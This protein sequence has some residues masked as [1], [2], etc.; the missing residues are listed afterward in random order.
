VKALAI[1][2]D[3]R[4]E[5]VATC[6]VGAAAAIYALVALYLTR[7][8]VPTYDSMTWLVDAAG[9]QSPGEIL[10][11]HN[12]HL[13]AVTRAFYA[14]SLRIFGTDPVAFEAFQITAVIATAVLLF[15][16]L[17]QRIDSLVAASAAVLVL[18]LGSPVILEPTVAVFAQSAA[19]G[20]GALLALGRGD[21]VGDALG[22]LLLLAGVAAFS[23]GLAFVA[24]AAA[25][26]AARRRWRDAWIVLVP[27]AAYVAWYAWASPSEAAGS[28]EVSAANVLLIPS[29]AADSLAAGLAVLAGLGVDLNEATPGLVS[30]G[31]GRIMA[32]AFVLLLVYVYLIRRRPLSAWV[33]ALLVIALAYWSMQAIVSQEF[34]GPL[35]DRYVFLSAVLCVLLLVELARGVPTARLVVIAAALLAFALPPSLAQMRT[36]GNDMRARSELAKAD[37]GAVELARDDLD[38]SMRVSSGLLQPVAA[39][40]YLEMADSYGALGLSPEEIEAAPPAIRRAVDANLVRLLPVAAEPEERASQADCE[41][42]QP[43]APGEATVPQGGLHLRTEGGGELALRRFGDEFVGSL[44]LPA[45][46]S[47]LLI[48]GDESDRPWVARVSAEGA[49]AL[50]GA[51]GAGE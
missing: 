13:I 26:V 22:C 15:V 19:L 33:T 37:L 23:A 6:V 20:L 34:R 47:S 50:C 46:E 49:V 18:F 9:E 32:G 2:D 48:P 27:L 5:R 14:L 51:T 35:L 4:R 41:R 45:G 39:G 42:I 31:W 40:E 36:T 11:P 21:R 29:F 30:I 24:G 17:R 3:P 44:D 28:A 12:G 43:G 25:L 38:P 8:T 7:G 10:T 1:G 16:L